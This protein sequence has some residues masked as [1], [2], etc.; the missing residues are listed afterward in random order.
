[1][2]KP[3][4]KQA[5]CLGLLL[6][7]MSS[8]FAQ[9]ALQTPAQF[10]GYPLGEQFTYHARM[11]DYVRYL[12]SQNQNK[13]QV[14]TYGHTYE[15]R[16]L[17]LATISS[18]ANMQRLEEIKANNLKNT[19]LVNG[20]PSGGK[21]PAIVWL[22]YNIHGN[23][24]VSSEAV[25][26]VLF[27]LLDPNNAQT[28][29]WLENTVVLL[30]PCVNPDGR[31]R[32]T[33]WYNRVRNQKPNASPYAW[34][35]QEPWPGG[36]P[37][38]YF[39]D[40]NRD[41]AWQTQIESKQ[42]AVVYN[43]WMPQLHADFHEQAVDNPYY[44]APS[45]KPYHD[46]I[47]PWQREAQNFIGDYNRKY[48]DKNNWLYFTRESFDLFYPSYGDTWPTYQGAIAMTYE[49]GGSGRAGVVIQKADGDSLTLSQRI[50]HHHAASLATVEAMS[51]KADQVVKEFRK[52]YADAQSKPFGQY[53]SYVFKAKGEEGRLKDLT[54]YLDRQQIRYGY[55]K[56]SGSSK[57]F[58]YQ[59]GK[60]E[61]VKYESGDLVISAFQPKS[62]LLNVLFEPAARLE[63][64]VTYDITAWSLPYAYGLKGAAFTN[65]I[66]FTEA[67]P[68]A[69]VTN[70]PAPATYAYIAP[71]NGIQDLKFMAALLQA[72]VR[73]RY[74]EV[75]FEQNNV[76]Y[77]PGTLIITR[78]G[79]EGLGPKFDQLVTRAADSLGIKLASTAT[80]FV[81]TG[82][83]F[84][85]RSIRYV[86]APRVALLTGEGVSPYGFG[87]IWHYFE[88]Q[89]GY[90]VTVLGGDYFANVPLHEFDVLILPTGSYTRIL[91]EKTLNKV[92]DWVRAGG[93]LIAM[94]NAVTFLADK[95]DF[96]VKKKTTDTTTS[97]KAPTAEDLKKYGNRERESI[98]EEVQGSVF[99][100]NLDNTHP[101]AFGYG[102]TY[103][104]LV[105]TS[106][107][108][109]FMK[110]AWNVGVVKEEPPVTGFVGSKV[111]NNLQNG[112]V[113]GVQDLGRGQVVYLV[114]NPLFRGFWQGG[115]LLFGNAVFLVGQ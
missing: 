92:K 73:V 25:L 81:T 9:G 5:L 35:H 16:P 49:Q 110:D 45:A 106:T 85:S 46:A 21:Q 28:Q 82:S 69:P 37:N 86:K 95:P 6:F 42:R 64:S 62:T 18:P 114:D 8:A 103:S 112:L 56:S 79:N 98:S 84:G 67:K 77:A 26:Q 87:E 52:F 30:D 97:K 14:Q 55:A 115:K 59:T 38:H 89:V 2:L 65:R 71:W 7:G 74:S 76:K 13:M 1:M 24:S 102:K 83:D 17:L 88:Q 60:T 44:F 34:E 12:A 105:R 94:E 39:F 40:L 48:F 70:T 29:K 90:P 101:L 41:W 108:P 68:A 36:R 104:A 3:L 54:Q 93:K 22:S 32:Y 43:Q 50:A 19:G 20:Q 11:V 61:S 113:L 10:L 4:F 23:E 80:G 72:K 31:E 15:N 66:S 109:H 57:G 107:L 53:R 27:D 33:Q 99:R 63:D 91:E 111:Q 75:P 47:T 78:T 96:A 58:N 51:D 100:I